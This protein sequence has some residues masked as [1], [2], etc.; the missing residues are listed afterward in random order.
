MYLKK[1]PKIMN[2]EKNASRQKSADSDFQLA[3]S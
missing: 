3:F 1:T 2:K